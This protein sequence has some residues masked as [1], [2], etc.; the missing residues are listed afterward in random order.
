MTNWTTLSKNMGA[1]QVVDRELP[2]ME[3]LHIMV[4]VAYV[5][6]PLRPH[7]FPYPVLTSTWM[8]EQQG[9]KLFFLRNIISLHSF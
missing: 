1:Q 6:R 2:H 5:D 4:I 8:V 3:M 9:V 7:T